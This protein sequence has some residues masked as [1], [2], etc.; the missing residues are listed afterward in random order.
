MPHIRV[1]LT[2]ETHTALKVKAVKE[3]KTIKSI[4]TELLTNYIK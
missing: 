1:E 3:K 2:E 4:I